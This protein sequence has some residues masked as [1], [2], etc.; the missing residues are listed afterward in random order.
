M[1]TNTVSAG[2]NRRPECEAIAPLLTLCDTGMLD[3][4]ENERVERHLTSCTV[5]QRDAALDSALAGHIRDALLSPVHSAHPLTVWEI[6]HAAEE[7]ADAADRAAS[8]ASEDRPL[9]GRHAVHLLPSVASRYGGLSALAAVLAVVLL[10][11]YI[12]GS[13]TGNATRLGP[14]PKAATLSPMLA[15]ETVYLPTA[16][17]IYALRASDGVV[18]WAF[19]AGITTLP[20]NSSQAIY[21]LALDHGTL[22]TLASMPGYRSSA[23][24]PEPHLYALN[25]ADGSV[26]WS[27]QVPDPAVTSLL[28]VGHLLVVAPAATDT[29]PVSEDNDTVFAFDTANGNL[30]WRRTLDEPTLSHAFA[31]G[32][33]VYIGTTQ[34]VVALNAADGTVRWT[35]PIVPGAYQQG[36]KLFEANSSVALAASGERVYVLGKRVITPGD[37]TH[38]AAWEASFY[39]IA[40]RDGTRLWRDT[41]ENDRWD[42]AF[43]PTVVGDT[44]YVALG[45]GITAFSLNG[46]SPQERWRFIPRS[47]PDFSTSQDTAMTKAVVSGGVVYATDL[48]G[49]LAQRNGMI[50]MENSIYAVRASDGVEL[51]RTPSDG[52]VM[53]T[54]PTVADGLLLA[55]SSI[56]LR[57]FH[58]GDGH[59]LWQ[60]IPPGGSLTASP[61]VGP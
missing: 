44:A 4:E 20:I 11:A 27:V 61:L 21:G 45:G 28:Q 17:G 48:T 5:C 14:V 40:A 41:V 50:S 34:H 13:H 15:Q 38:G 42:A 54:T 59:P 1:T 31:A 49:T 24:E 29:P 43:A 32:G 12:F 57:V 2:I 9:A 46:A 18:R 16:D 6:A 3:A 22:Y 37:H 26:R 55:P 35:S 30:V 19:P 33:S 7:E 58:A 25:A 36:T 56:V 52:G 10:A 39:V 8:D 60:Y 51:W 47:N 53:A 23:H